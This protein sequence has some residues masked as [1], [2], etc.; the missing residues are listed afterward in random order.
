[1]RVSTNPLPLRQLRAKRARK[2]QVAATRLFFTAVALVVLAN[3]ARVVLR[4]VMP[5]MLDRCCGSVGS[6]DDERCD[7]MR[8]RCARLFGGSPEHWHI[9]ATV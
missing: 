3:V 7:A 5:R 1:M 2:C 9:S 6:A 8:A 4:Q